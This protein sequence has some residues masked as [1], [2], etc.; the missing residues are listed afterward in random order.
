MTCPAVSLTISQESVNLGNA[1]GVSV[2]GIAGSG[3]KRL[4]SVEC[5]DGKAV[6]GTASC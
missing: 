6:V 4:R 1:E 3:G 2:V 5:N